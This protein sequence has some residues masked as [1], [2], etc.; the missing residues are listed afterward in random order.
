MNIKQVTDLKAVELLSKLYR[1]NSVKT[2]G[3]METFYSIQL[4]D[5]NKWIFFNTIFVMFGI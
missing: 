2:E 5:T 4:S 3:R 1:P